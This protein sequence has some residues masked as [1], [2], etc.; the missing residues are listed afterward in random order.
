MNQ[1]QVA[2]NGRALAMPYDHRLAN[3]LGGK[4]FTV[5]GS[6]FMA[7]K[8]NMDTYRMMD[9]LGWRPPTPFDYQYQWPVGFKPF[10]AQQVTAAL[11]SVSQKAYVLNGMGT[12]KTAATAAAADYC[13]STGQ[14]NKAIITAPLSTLY[15]VWRHELFKI[16]P[17]RKAVVLHATAAKRRELLENRAFDF[18]IINHG[19]LHIIA[20]A[21]LYRPDINLAIIDELAEFR[22]ARTRQ[23]RTLHQIVEGQHMTVWGLT[24]TPIPNAPTDAWAQVR[25]LTPER[26][27][28]TF[29]AFRAQTMIPLENN[30]WA[31]RVGALDIVHKA[32]Q[33]GVRFKRSQCI[34]LP[35]V[36][37]SFRDV[38]LSPR[39]QKAYRD[40][41][42]KFQHEAAEGLITAANEGVKIG[43]LL[44]ISCGWVYDDNGET[45]PMDP[46]SRLALTV[47]LIRASE[48]KALVLV[49]FVHAIQHVHKYITKQGITAGLIYGKTPARKRTEIIS[50]FQTGPD[51]HVIVAHSKTMAHGLNLT[52]ANTTIWFSPIMSSNQME[53][54]NNRMPRPGQIRNM[55]IIQLTATP[56]EKEVYRRFYKRQSM[57]NLLLDMFKKQ[58]EPTP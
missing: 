45:V 34:D 5:N 37:D 48:G 4:P 12:G 32:M 19:A 21:L 17:H 44:Q 28:T 2:A 42:T 6:T 27:A 31:P 15:S 3:V 9:A 16:C 36:T 13:M 23:W 56:V 41:F 24:G 10:E 8:F 39:V 58:T 30:K 40:M 1:I 33:P 29:S 20:E 14:V 35:T 26:I 51:P 54:A 55:H 47:D 52:A 7:L 57:Q 18:Y 11:M 38:Y 25:L 46:E 49:P 43:K 53:Q 22:N 50:N